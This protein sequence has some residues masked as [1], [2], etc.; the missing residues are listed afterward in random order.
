MGLRGARW[1]GAAVGGEVEAVRPAAVAQDTRRRAGRG[2]SRAVCPAL[3]SSRG[4]RGWLLSSGRGGSVAGTG[5]R[6]GP[7][8]EPAERGSGEGLG[9]AENHWTLRR[10]EALLFCKSPSFYQGRDSPGAWEQLNQPSF[11]EEL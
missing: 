5:Q 4:L 9:L 11:R 1:A 2:Q 10:Y 7:L 8:V 3:C 6:C